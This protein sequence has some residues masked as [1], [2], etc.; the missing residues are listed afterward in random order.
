MQA[1]VRLLLSGSLRLLVCIACSWQRELRLVRVREIINYFQ[2]ENTQ[3]DYYL[4]IFRDVQNDEEEI[5]N[6]RY[7]RITFDII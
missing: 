4:V 3:I 5:K 1:R 6:V 2:D 7:N